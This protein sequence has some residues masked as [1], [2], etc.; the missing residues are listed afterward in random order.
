[1]GRRKYASKAEIAEEAVVRVLLFA[2]SIV[3]TGVV[4]FALIPYEMVYLV[5][6]KPVYLA[7]V[8]ALWGALAAAFGPA[9]FSGNRR[10]VPLNAVRKSSE[11]SETREVPT[12]K[13]AADRP[14]RPPPPRATATKL[15]KPRETKEE[16]GSEFW[17]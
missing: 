16:R 1:M 17:R 3:L 2:G 12:A 15:R 14:T 13:P 7:V 9:V 6:E 5:T 4:L 10:H 8:L 11:P